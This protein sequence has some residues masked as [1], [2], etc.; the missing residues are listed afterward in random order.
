MRKNKKY[1][2][3]V[4]RK[5]LTGICK[6]I[7]FNLKQTAQCSDHTAEECYSK[8]SVD[9]SVLVPLTFLDLCVYCTPIITQWLLVRLPMGHKTVVIR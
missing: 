9:E 2:F 3:S 8:P 1:T 7:K 5:G 6:V 4:C